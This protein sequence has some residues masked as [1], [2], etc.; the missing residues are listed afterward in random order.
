MDASTSTVLIPIDKIDR[1]SLSRYRH[2]DYDGDRL[3]GLSETI[4]EN[5]LLQ[6]IVVR[7]EDNG[8]GGQSYSLVAGGR[9]LAAIDL[10]REEDGSFMENGVPAVLV[11][12]DNDEMTTATLIENH[13]REDTDPDSYA[14]GIYDLLQMGIEGKALARKT[15]NSP[16]LISNYNVYI[17]NASPKIRREVQ[18]GRLAFNAAFQI[19]QAGNAKAQAEALKKLQAST[20][21]GK[22]PTAT[23]AK[24]AAGKAPAKPSLKELRLEKDATE[25][26][27]KLVAEKEGKDNE[28]FYRLMGRRDGLLFALG[29]GKA[30]PRPKQGTKKASPKKAE[31]AK[32]NAGKVKAPKKKAKKAKTPTAKVPKKNLPTEA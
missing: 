28:K 30:L 26:K 11:T 25:A 27:A 15:G 12:G 1:D 21:K 23:A 16:A 32:A 10:I 9:R 8:A 31:A 14:Q 4:L 19:V 24:Q 20:P 13:Q 22:R 2:G 7:V 17:S 6:P 5:G 3:R 18:E 29:Q